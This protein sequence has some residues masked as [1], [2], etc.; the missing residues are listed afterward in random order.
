MLDGL[1][2]AGHKL[3]SRAQ[4]ALDGSHGSQVVLPSPDEPDTTVLDK[5]K[6]ERDEGGNEDEDEEEK[7]RKRNGKYFPY[8][9]GFFNSA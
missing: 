3:D 1:I 4:N 2:Q 6:G 7:P 5:E 9:G 8:H